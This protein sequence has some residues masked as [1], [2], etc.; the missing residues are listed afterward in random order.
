MRDEEHPDSKQADVVKVFEKIRN[1]RKQKIGEVI[2][3]HDE[4]LVIE[5]TLILDAKDVESSEK[6][7]ILEQII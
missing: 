3:A 7:I 4:D 6:L 2:I 1:V 5:Q